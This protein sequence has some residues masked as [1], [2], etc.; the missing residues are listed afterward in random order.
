MRLNIQQKAVLLL[1]LIEVT[2]GVY[3]PEYIPEPL[4]PRAVAVMKWLDANLPPTDPAL[5]EIV[6]M[7][8]AGPGEEYGAVQ[9]SEFEIVE[10]ITQLMEAIIAA[11]L[12]PDRLVE[13]P[14][15]H[16]PRKVVNG[17]PRNIR[18]HG[19]KQ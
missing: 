11:E 4:Q 17:R 1:N 6:D 7:P 13:P 18:R 19:R 5:L 12:S 2:K 10:G 3:G 16:V 8:P 9:I 14:R 15:P